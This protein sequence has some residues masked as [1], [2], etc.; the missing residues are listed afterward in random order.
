VRG[1][2]DYH[3]E[4]LLFILKDSESQYLNNDEIN[5]LSYFLPLRGG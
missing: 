2:L 1:V 3:P 4:T 5:P